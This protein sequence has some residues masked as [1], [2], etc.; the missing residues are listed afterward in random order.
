MGAQTSYEAEAAISDENAVFTPQS[1]EST[2]PE[3]AEAGKQDSDAELGSSNS[4]Q[5]LYR[6]ERYH[7]WEPWEGAIPDDDTEKYKK[8]IHG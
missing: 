8:I 3:D 1:S 6:K 4:A 7:D 2:D 5:E